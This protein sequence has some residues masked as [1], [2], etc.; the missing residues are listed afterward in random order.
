MSA[1]EREEDSDPQGG[2]HVKTEAEIGDMLS[3]CPKNTQA[4]EEAG[5]ILQSREGA[6]PTPHLEFGLRP[7]RK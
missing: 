7:V 6:W 1:Q 4:L 3:D 2:G 5:R